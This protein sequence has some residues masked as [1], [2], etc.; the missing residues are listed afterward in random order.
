M[1]LEN[2]SFGSASFALVH[3]AAAPATAGAASSTSVAMA[4]TMRRM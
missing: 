2:G 3:G 1:S 4:R